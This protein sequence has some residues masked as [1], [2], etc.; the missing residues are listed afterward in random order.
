MKL[1]TKELMKLSPAERAE[2]RTILQKSDRLV[3]LPELAIYTGRSINSIRIYSHQGLLPEPIGQSDRFPI[4][5]RE[6]IDE[7]NLSF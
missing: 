7:W 1:T 5:E 6:D 4:W 2:L 3:G